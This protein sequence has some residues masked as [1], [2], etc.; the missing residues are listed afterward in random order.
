MSNL[1]SDFNFSKSKS[2]FYKKRYSCFEIYGKIIQ[3]SDKLKFK[4][5]GIVSLYSNNKIDFIIKFYALSKSGFG[6]YINDN[7][8]KNDIL[9][10]QI[11][12]N[13]YFK[14][15]RLVKIKS[16]KP[17]FVN[18]KLVIL[19]TSGSTN[20]NKYVFL[21]HKNISYICN[22]MNKTMFKNKETENELIFAPLNH[23]F[24]FGR[25][26][27]LIKSSNSLTIPNHLS[28]SNFFNILEKSNNISALSITSGFFTKLLK[29]DLPK[30]KKILSKINYIQISSGF[31]PIKLRKEILKMKT[32]LFINYGMTE[33]MR[34]TFLDCMQYKNKI[35][36]EGKPF[37]GIKI[38]ILKSKNSSKGEIMIKGKNVAKSY[39]DKKEWKARI[40]NGWFKTG[41]LGKLDKD[42]FLIY[43]NRISD[44][45]NIN[46]ISYSKLSIEKLIQNKFK[47]SIIK[48]INIKNEK[49]EKLY[50]LSDKK[51]I[52][53]MLYKFL[54]KKKIKIIFEKI[55]YKKEINA[56][57]LGKISYNK[58]LKYINE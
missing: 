9:K 30:S 55:I 17:K 1:F 27:S 32:N 57:I 56:G 51:I 39:S 34:S 58:F 48:I 13:Y 2:I 8:N 38:K 28:F 12:I 24:A 37:A 20:I 54:L 29:L 44:N 40:I 52:K 41:D 33:A 10:E 5:K 36:T 6:I 7:N 19:R 35:H 23:A 4:K 46:D 15:N 11:D 16:F 42:N 18:K 22:M 31:F 21:T 45:L 25:L 47:T 3:L 53:E 26:H 50:L 43:L 14:N 49:Q